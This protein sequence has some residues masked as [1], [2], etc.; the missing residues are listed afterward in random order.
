MLPLAIKIS[1]LSP[2]A[3]VH[4]ITEL[5][6]PFLPVVLK[7]PS[8]E[9]TSVVLLE[10]ICVKL[11]SSLMHRVLLRHILIELSLHVLWS[12]PLIII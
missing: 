3:L 5:A 11:I 2:T 10:A 8:A 1:V 6:L 4:L 9:S 7:T 12:L